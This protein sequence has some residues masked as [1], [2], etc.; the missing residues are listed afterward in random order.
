MKPHLLD[1]EVIDMILRHATECIGTDGVD[2]LRGHILTLTALLAA[3][4]AHD[5]E[6][7]KERDAHQETLVL[8]NKLVNDA[9]RENATLKAENARLREALESLVRDVADYEAWQRPCLALDRARAALAAM[10]VGR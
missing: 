1:Q 2:G 10:G 6:L 3:I 8:M 9:A 5:S 4:A 7:A